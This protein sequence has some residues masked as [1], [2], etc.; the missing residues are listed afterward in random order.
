MAWN[1][2]RPLGTP[3]KQSQI[4]MDLFDKWRSEQNM[5]IADRGSDADPAKEEEH[6]S[7]MM[8]QNLNAYICY[9]Q[10]DEYTSCLAKHHI[11]EHT[12]RGHEINTKN[13]INERKC[14]GTH[15]SYVACMG[16]QKNQET[17]LHSAVLHNN[18][19]EFHAELMCCYDKNR[20]LET[21]TSEPLC[22]P[23]YRGL[24]RCGL[25]HLWNDY[26]RALTRFGEAEEF[27]LYELSRD[28][29]KKQEFLRVITSTVEQQQEYLRK[30]RE[31]EKG[32]F[33]PRPD[34]EIESS[35]EKMKA[36]AAV[37]AQERQ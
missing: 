20:E 31:Q 15:K 32:Y 10:L 6:N 26:W 29:N 23:F 14:R 28:D 30:R 3:S 4:S 37:L 12:D 7:F 19:R 34:K 22:I 8:R 21:E 35:D 33:L 16:S 24:L 17:L 1:A 36:A 18:C 9:K 13:N 2:W 25:N 5:S 11:I 27:H